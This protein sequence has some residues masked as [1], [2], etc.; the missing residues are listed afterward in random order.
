MLLVN[1]TVQVV[2]II[3]IIQII[4]IMVKVL[5]KEKKEVEGE[6]EEKVRTEDPIIKN[7]VKKDNI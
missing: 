4:Q 6:G 5:E 1:Q 2:Q 3:Q 7:H